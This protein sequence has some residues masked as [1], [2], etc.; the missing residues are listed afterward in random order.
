MLALFG[1]RRVHFTGA[2]ALCVIIAG[3][4]A[5][6]L[7]GTATTVRVEETFK[8]MWLIVAQPLL[9]VLIG[10]SVSVSYLDARFV[11]EGIIILLVGLIVRL[12]ASIA[13]LW[14]PQFTLKERVFVALAW[15]P[16]AT[17]QAAIGA[18]VL[19]TAKQQEIVS[20]EE[21]KF[22]EQILTIAVLSIML[23][24]PIGAAAI[25]FGGPR[26]LERERECSYETASTVAG[27]EATL[28]V[29][30]EVDKGEEGDLK[31]EGATSTL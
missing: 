15:F 7:W 3:V 22:G 31:G 28:G 29:L 12:L 1:G 30:V 21:V 23:T 10:S 11:G 5:A 14:T 16:K 20:E 25:A 26:L 18:A 19:D 2:G 13:C 8:E 17:V 9:F 24:A 27:D 4:V 6:R